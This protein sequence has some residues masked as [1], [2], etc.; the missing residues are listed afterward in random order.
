VDIFERI[1]RVRKERKLTQK[2]VADWF[3]ISDASYGRKEKGQ[4]GGFGPAEIQ[5]FIEKTRVDARYLFGQLDVWEE[6]DLDRREQLAEAERLKSENLR[7]IEQNNELI[8][9]IPENAFESPLMRILQRDEIRLLVQAA[10]SL[11]MLKVG[12]VI[13]YIDK[14]LESEKAQPGDEHM[15]G[16][17]PR[18]QSA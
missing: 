2:D 3:G 8:R 14:L 17:S 1:K 5:T 4:E 6:A 10:K 15:G 11:D 18:G 7:L 13:G 9:R 12:R 16:A